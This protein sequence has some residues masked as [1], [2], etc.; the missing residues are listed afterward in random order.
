MK[1]LPRRPVNIKFRESFM[2]SAVTATYVWWMKNS[3]I[4][5]DTSLMFLIKLPRR[6]IVKNYHDCI[7]SC[8]HQYQTQKKYEPFSAKVFEALYFVS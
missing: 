7:P 3:Q 4:P 6:W 1:D 8:C 2:K 5:A